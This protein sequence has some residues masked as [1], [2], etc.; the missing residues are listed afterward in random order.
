MIDKATS[1][2]IANKY[3]NDIYRFCASKLKNADAADVTQDVFLLFQEKCPYLDDVNI[4]AWLLSVASKKI[5]EKYRND[6]KEL[7]LKERLEIFDDVITTVEETCQVTE[8][9]VLK[10]KDE[11]LSG[12]S[13][14]EKRLY[15]MIYT[16]RRKYADIA[17]ELE[18][19]EK[20]ISM[21]AFRLN[22]KIKK[23]AAET[24]VH[25]SSILL[26]I[27]FFKNF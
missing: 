24:I 5:Y 27:L 2:R 13:E 23:L 19:T 9:E 12:L 4:S 25:M 6:K 7:T 15:E 11:V 26:Y 10:A 20:A 16:Q 8:E 18:T 1:D 21:K 14:K 22:K 17:R 3:Y